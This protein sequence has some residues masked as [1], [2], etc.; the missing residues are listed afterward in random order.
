MFI[1]NINPVLLQ[2]G[3]FQIRYYGVI[4]ALGF[5]LAAIMLYWLAGKR[6]IEN[7]ER[8]DV[9]N[10]MIYLIIGLLFFSRLFEIVFYEPAYYFSHPL[11][12]LAVWHGG[13]SFHGGLFGAVLVCL[14]YTR[15]KKVKFYDLTDILVIPAAIGLAF[16]R[17]A[18][19]INGEL[20]GTV[21]NVPWCVK[22]KNAEGCRHPSQLYESLKNFFIF[23]TLL[24][25]SRFKLKSGFL[26][27]HFVLMYGAIRFFIEFVRYSEFHLLGL[28]TGQMFCIA[29]V[30]TAVIFIIKEKYYKLE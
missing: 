22:F 7:F 1:H 18:N 12:M 8:K 14:I 29:M 2:L 16:G 23:F 11:E 6:K 24:F 20:W 21:T 10:F 13:L 15:Y 5:A 4:F 19:F 9:A 25:L 17:I 26:F 3:P 30:I 27:W 28:S